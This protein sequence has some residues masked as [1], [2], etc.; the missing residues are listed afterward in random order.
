MIN[1]NHDARKTNVKAEIEFEI[2]GNK[3]VTNRDWKY[4]VA[5]GAKINWSRIEISNTAVKSKEIAGAVN[6]MGK[7]RLLSR[8]AVN[9]VIPISFIHDYINRRQTVVVFI[10]YLCINITDLSVLIIFHD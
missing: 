4:I 6:E 1:R 7:Y 2:I 3:T 8:H 5:R 9:F 10:M